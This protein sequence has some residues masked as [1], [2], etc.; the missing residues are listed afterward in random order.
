MNATDSPLIS[1]CAF[2]DRVVRWICPECVATIKAYWDASRDWEYS[3]TGYY[4]LFDADTEAQRE[5]FRQADSALE[6]SPADAFNDF[7]ELAREGSIV[8]MHLV[9]WCYSSGT[10]V[11]ANSSRARRWYYKAIVAGSWCATIDYARLLD[12]EGWYAE[13]DEVLNDGIKAGLATS[14][15]W[16]ARL[17]FQRAPGRA[18]AQ[19]AKGLL[20]YA[21]DRGHLGAQVALSNLYVSGRLGLRNIPRGFRLMRERSRKYPVGFEKDLNVSDG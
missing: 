9:A 16:L 20:E 12:K 14:H 4:D 13:C 1:G 7:R 3:E 10:G 18:T 8:S 2:C 17:R 6:I 11:R 21:V 5:R 19:A 15:Y